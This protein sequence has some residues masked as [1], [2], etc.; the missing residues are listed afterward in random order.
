MKRENLIN[1]A[2][3]FLFSALLLQ[4]LVGC[5]Q[6]TTVPT[7]TSTQTETPTLAKTTTPSQTLTQTHVVVRR[8]QVLDFITSLSLASEFHGA[9]SGQNAYHGDEITDDAYLRGYRTMIEALHDKTG[10]WPSI[11]GVDYEWARAFTPAQ[12]SDANEVLINYSHSGGIVMVTFTPQNPWLNDET[13]L[14]NN[15]GSGDGP[16]S[17]TSKMPSGASLDD[18]LNPEKTV[19]A[20][21]MRKL[22]RIAAALLELKKA[23]V[24]VL[25]RPMQEMNGVWFW[26][27]IDSHRTDPEPYI[28]V[29]RAMRDYFEKDKGLDN[30]IWVYSPTSTYGNETVT[31][32]VFRAVDWAYPGDNYVD[33]IAGTNYADDMSISDYGT[34]VKMGKPLGIAEYGPN[35]D[36]PFFKN[37][38]WD[39]TRIIERLKNDYPRIAFWVCWHSYPGSSW[40]MV[41]NLNADILLADPFVINRDDLPWNNE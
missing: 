17:T 1:N 20:S 41:S 16:S 19:Y 4:G 3:I 2:T 32:Y 14:V 35:S 15:P 31:N 27:G 12:L 29:Y 7:P 38:T 22:D 9:I 10:E 6:A 37:G 28:R 26:W 34:Y 25:F 40:S 11:I 39:L 5:G 21:W 24:V 33:I 8:A 13:D 23:R 30:L 18:L 36:G